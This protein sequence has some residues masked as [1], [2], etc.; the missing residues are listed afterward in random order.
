MMDV[1]LKGLDC[2]K[3]LRR[4]I[5][6]GLIGFGKRAVRNVSDYTLGGEITNVISHTI[7]AG[8]D[9]DVASCII[10]LKDQYLDAI[11]A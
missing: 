5:I 1:I 8:V 3:S 6:S 11:N 2:E 9:I 7:D 4:K 10:D